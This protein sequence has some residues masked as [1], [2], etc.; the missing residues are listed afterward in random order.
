MSAD[1]EQ[2]N[3]VTP[4]VREK[5]DGEPCFYS[6]GGIARSKKGHSCKVYMFDGSGRSIFVGLVTI[7]DLDKLLCKE[8]NVIMISKYGVAPSATKATAKK[9]LG[10]SVKLADPESLK[11]GNN[12]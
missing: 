3:A 9:Q 11:D 7:N 12:Q 6:T 2:A 4:L 5:A 10:F 1:P 8:K